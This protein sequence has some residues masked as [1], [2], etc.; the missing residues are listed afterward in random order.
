MGGPYST[1][2]ANHP[3][4]AIK[5]SFSSSGIVHR[6]GPGGFDH[7]EASVNVGDLLGVHDADERHIAAMTSG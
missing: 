4:A 2:A 6:T 7:V 5:P 1:A 3:H